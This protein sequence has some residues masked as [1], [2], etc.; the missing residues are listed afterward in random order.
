MCSTYVVF[1]TFLGDFRLSVDDL[2]RLPA[3]HCGKRSVNSVS[4]TVLSTSPKFVSQSSIPP[5]SRLWKMV[6]GTRYGTELTRL[7]VHIIHALVLHTVCTHHVHTYIC[8]TLCSIVCRCTPVLCLVMCRVLDLDSLYIDTTF[9][10]PNV[11]SLP[12]R[13]CTMM[14]Q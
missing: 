4:G 1:S 8:R 6:D 14:V 5:M 9:C 7:F 13:V 11:A 3:L 2:Q 12:S 10:H